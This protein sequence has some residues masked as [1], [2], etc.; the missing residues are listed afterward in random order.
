MHSNMLLN[1]NMVLTCTY[2]Y[3]SSVYCDS[4][5]PGGC[6]WPLWNDPGSEFQASVE[7]AMIL[8]QLRSLASFQCI[9]MWESLSVTYQVIG[10]LQ[11]LK[12]SWASK[13]DR[14]HMTLDIESGDKLEKH[15]IQCTFLLFIQACFM[16]Y[17]S[18]LKVLDW[19]M[20]SVWWLQHHKLW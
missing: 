18:A 17:E 7:N 15:L 19:M 4:H 1:N 11:V 5:S 14:H 20:P 6:H 3:Y 2:M 10:L 16:G 12:F 9:C 13:A 8:D